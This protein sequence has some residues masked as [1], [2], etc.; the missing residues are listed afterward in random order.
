MRQLNVV[1][2]ESESLVMGKKVKTSKVLVEL[3]RPSFGT[4]AG[5]ELQGW[6]QERYGHKGLGIPKEN[7]PRVRPG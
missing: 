6:A 3:M 2:L 1:P 7:L 4:P 5:S